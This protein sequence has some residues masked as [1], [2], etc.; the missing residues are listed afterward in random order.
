M[1][2]LWQT[3]AVSLSLA[4]SGTGNAIAQT[5]ITVGYQLM[6]NPLEGGNRRRRNRT[7]D[8]SDDINWRPF[9]SGAKVINAIASGSVKLGPLRFQPDR[10]RRQP[11]LGHR[12]GLGVRGH[13]GGRGLGGAGRCGHCRP[14]GPE[15]QDHRC[16]LCFHHPF[17]HPLRAG[18]VRHRAGG[19]DNQQSPAAGHRRGL[20][21]RRRSMLR[22]F[23]IPALGEIK[24]TGKVLIT[25]GLLS[26]WGKATFD[27]MVVDRQFAAE[28]AD[29]MCKLIKTVAA[30]DESYRSNPEAWGP[31]SA[32]GHR[33]R[34]PGGGR[35]CPGRGRPRS[36]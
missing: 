6:Y 21:W 9:E 16:A 26:S 35:S 4:I 30:A 13:R 14:S 22:S 12:G 5:E 2:A 25:S 3:L 8:G 29:F 10:R 28:N 34:R 19:G 33:H 27:A 32:A 17:S 20:G 31:D 1:R 23:G 18:A 15:G 24:K 7:G 36:L 11:R